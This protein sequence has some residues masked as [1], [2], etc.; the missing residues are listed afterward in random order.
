MLFAVP[1]LAQSDEGNV[2]LQLPPRRRQTVRL[3]LSAAEVESV[4]AFT[5]ATATERTSEQLGEEACKY[6]FK[7]R[8][9]WDGRE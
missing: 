8:E 7:R 2:I 6:G 9:A 4:K 3:Q 5:D 1:I